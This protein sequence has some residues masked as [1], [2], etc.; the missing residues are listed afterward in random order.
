LGEKEGHA[1]QAALV[2]RL[3]T[4]T[5]TNGV[6]SPSATTQ[7]TIFPAGRNIFHILLPQVLE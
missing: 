4:V 5:A 1:V 2:G 7:V 3:A 6:V